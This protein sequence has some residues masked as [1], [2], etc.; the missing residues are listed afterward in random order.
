MSV[1]YNPNIGV[2]ES[3]AYHIDY[4]EIGFLDSFEWKALDRK[5]GF[6]YTQRCSVILPPSLYEVKREL[7]VAVKYKSCSDV[8]PDV[9]YSDPCTVDQPAIGE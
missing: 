8:D 3:E 5:E 9:I 4:I 7:K 6:N 2:R 1:A